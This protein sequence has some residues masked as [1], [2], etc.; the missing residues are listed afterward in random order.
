MRNH[1]AERGDEPTRTD[2][3]QDQVARSGR[4]SEVTRAKQARGPIKYAKSRCGARCRA[5]TDGPRAR[6]G[7]AVR[8]GERSHASEA[9]SR[10]N[11]ICEITLRSE[12]TSRHGR[13]AR[14]TRSRGPAG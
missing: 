3:A 5:D 7:R 10:S 9:G 6:P 1:V 14:K 13:T 12:V 8:P 2:R 4:V 11:Q